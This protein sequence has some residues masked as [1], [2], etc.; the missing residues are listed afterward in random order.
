MR[1]KVDAPA[2]QGDAGATTT[3]KAKPGLSPLRRE[4]TAVPGAAVAPG[5]G[6]AG[7]DGCGASRTGHRQA[8]QAPEVPL[9]PGTRR[10]RGCR[11]VA[12]ERRTQGLR[13]GCGRR[14]MTGMLLS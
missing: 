3:L 14:A 4:Q 8:R 7:A 2:W 12:K 6:R 11:A 1:M 5:T 10:W 13:A 9:P